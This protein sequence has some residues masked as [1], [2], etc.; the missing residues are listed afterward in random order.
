LLLL[1]RGLILEVLGLLL[2]LCFALLAL[3]LRVGL[4]GLA[5]VVGGDGGD[6]RAVDVD[7]GRDALVAVLD[8]G[9][10]GGTTAIGCQYAYGNLI[11]VLDGVNL[12]GLSA[13]GAVL[14]ITDMNM[15][16]NRA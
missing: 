7:E 13:T 10:S 4:Y 11:A 16:A 12:S 8:L 15:S 14:E 5:L 1:N 2:D 6:V 3:G 9:Q